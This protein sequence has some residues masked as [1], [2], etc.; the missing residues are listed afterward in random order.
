VKLA[1]F[2]QYQDD[3]G[4]EEAI[5]HQ[6]DKHMAEKWAFERLLDSDVKAITVTKVRK[7][8]GGKKGRP[9]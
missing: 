3:T 1:I 9:R 7:F 6:D 2:V 8:A 5:F 4:K